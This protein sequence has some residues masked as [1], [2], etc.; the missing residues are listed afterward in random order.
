MNIGGHKSHGPYANVSYQDIAEWSHTSLDKRM[1][2]FISDVAGD[3]VS[4]DGGQDEGGDAGGSNATYYRGHD[5]SATGCVCVCV[6]VGV[7]L[8][9]A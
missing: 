1:I 6:C 7:W 8:A 2:E 4:Q 5:N 9:V 3:A